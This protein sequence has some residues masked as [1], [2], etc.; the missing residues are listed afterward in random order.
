MDSLKFTREILESPPLRK[1]DVATAL[2]HFA[3][4]TYHV[5]ADVVR[6]LLHPRFEPDCVEINGQRRALLSVV[7][8]I[9][10]DFHFACM[11]WLRWRFAQTNYRIYVRDKV[12]GE[13]AVWF[14]GTSLDSWTVAIPRHRWNMPWHRARIS[15]DCEHDDDARRYTRYRMQT[16]RSW[17]DAE[18]ELADTGVP[19]TALPGFADLETAMV[20]LTH[21]MRGYYHR[22]DGRLGSYS[23]WHD[24][25]TPTVGSVVSAR[26]ALL[27]QMGLVDSGD[28]SSVHSVFLQPRTDFT[29]ALPPGI[30]DE[31]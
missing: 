31:A 20:V 25:L 10:Q 18:M 3:I 19:P 1:W 21:P 12:T 7:P 23:I 29:I 4:I 6:R 17:A 22:R 26:F 11:P 30:V 2:V 15:F 14:L 9:D 27:E 28:A 13:H 16:T 8:F 5:D 24:R